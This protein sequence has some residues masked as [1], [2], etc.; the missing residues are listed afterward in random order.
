[1]PDEVPPF[2]VVIVP[3]EIAETQEQ[4]DDLHEELASALEA[5][6]TVNNERYT[7]LLSEVQQCRN[8]LESLSSRL[9]A[10]VSREAE[11]PLLNQIMA[12]LTN[13]RSQL[14][15]VQAKMNGL[16]TQITTASANLRRNESTPAGPEETP[17]VV[18]TEERAPGELPETPP[19]APRKRF[20]A[21]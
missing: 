5:Q 14:T 4:A 11:S 1:M 21:I 6:S 12:E 3:E 8:Q 2:P 10:E 19:A 20:R 15:E 13:V 17:V 9:P 18:L 16:E 7:A